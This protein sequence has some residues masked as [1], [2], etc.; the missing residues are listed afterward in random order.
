MDL[1]FTGLRR[2]GEGLL[3]QLLLTCFRLLLCCLVGVAGDTVVLQAD[4]SDALGASAVCGASASPDG[5]GGA[6]ALLGSSAVCGASPD[7]VGGATGL[8]PASGGG[9]AAGGVT[10]LLPASGGGA[11]AGFSEC[12]GW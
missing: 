6:T 2:E 7:G 12:V 5:V 8:L 3:R 11:A 4:A 9:A 10:G 1:G